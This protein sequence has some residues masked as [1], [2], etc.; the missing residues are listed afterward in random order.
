MDNQQLSID[1]KMLNRR[2]KEG[3]GF[4]YKYTSPSGKSYIGQTSSTL[5][6]R[7]GNIYTG[8]GY[9]KCPIFW[10]AI[11]KYGWLSFKVEIL[12]E[13]LLNE[14]DTKE[15]EKI[16]QLQTLSPHG[17]NLS[18]GGE[19]GRKQEVFCYDAQNGEFLER[20]P[21]VSIASEMTGVAISI[22]S[23]ILNGHKNKY[24]HNLTFRKTFTPKIPLEELIPKNW[25]KVYVYDR[26]GFFIQA[27]PSATSAGQALGISDITIRSCLNGGNKQCKGYQFKTV[28]KDKIDP[29]PK[30]SKTPISVIQ[31]NPITK[32]EIARYPS[33]ISAAHA[34]GLTNGSGIKKVI[35]R[36]KGLSGGYFW[37][38]N[39]SSTT[40]CS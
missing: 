2:P 28:K 22:I 18:E 13:V 25:R 35:S 34:V 39:E 23:N 10:T 19:G 8:E 21:S 11:Q 17:Y 4:I 33:L 3:Y 30:N 14:L 15:T 31:I 12:E 5:K 26:N 24:T 40:T 37:K 32:A 29:I 38:I 36:G 7:A 27:F 1:F 6:R 9:K 20:Y 16:F